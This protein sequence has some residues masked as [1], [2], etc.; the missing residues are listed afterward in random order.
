MSASESKLFDSLNNPLQMIINTF[1]LYTFCHK[2]LN[3]AFLIFLKIFVI[4]S[5]DWR[6]LDRQIMEFKYAN[7]NVLESTSVYIIFK[8][9]NCFDKL[10]I[11]GQMIHCKSKQSLAVRGN[12]TTITTRVT[13][14]SLP[15][16]L[17]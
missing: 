13:S 10:S 2:S 5:R 1:F 7:Y 3:K 12:A 8:N 15:S 14:S 16:R 6:F 9:R 17:L 11:Q 4:D